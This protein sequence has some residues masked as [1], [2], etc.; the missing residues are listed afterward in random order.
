MRHYKI[1]LGL[2][3]VGAL[4]LFTESALALQHVALKDM[5]ASIT[6]Q[7]Q[8]VGKL[9]VAISYLMGFGFVFSSIYKF[10]QHKDNPTQIPIGGALALLGV[11][12]LMMFLPGFIAP[13]GKSMF[14]PGANLNQTAGGFS[15]EAAKYL[16]GG[17]DT[18][19]Q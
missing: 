2:L 14:G 6:S 19:S 8:A 13:A 16:P 3:S 1:I 9:I 7:Y 17:Q 4:F 5:V 12:I 15:G 11:G 18:S 10:K